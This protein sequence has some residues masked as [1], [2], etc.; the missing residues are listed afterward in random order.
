M[1]TGKSCF[2]IYGLVLMIFIS[3]VSLTD[4]IIPESE[5]E[6]T[7]IIGS[8]QT[9]FT[10]WQPLHIIMKKNI[11]EKAYSKLLEQAKIDYGVNIDVKNVTIDGSFSWHNLWA[12]LLGA[13]ALVYPGMY[14]LANEN[15]KNP[16]I[17]GPL[18]G[19]IGFV[20]SGNVQKI[21]ATGNVVPTGEYRALN[22]S[23]R[24]HTNT[25]MSPLQRAV[26]NASNMI[27]IRLPNESVLAVLNI[28]SP[29]TNIVNQVIDE[30]EFIF[31]S[32]GKFKIVDRR[33]LDAIMAEQHFQLSGNVDDNEAVSIG[34][35]IGANIV[36]TG[37]VIGTRSSMRLTLRALDVQTGQIITIARETF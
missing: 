12:N 16:V 28:E 5:I 20:I 7:E 25:I 18:G 2:F 19:V 26:Y 15:Y 8:V 31:V 9:T 11:K 34:K 33:A 22:Q 32:S 37:T 27:S 1:K 3:C 30:L 36:I 21:T 17:G 24:I 23:N 4:K 35:M 6:T 13:A 14:V 10:T 29:D